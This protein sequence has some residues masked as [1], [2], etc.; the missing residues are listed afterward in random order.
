LFAFRVAWFPELQPESKI[1]ESKDKEIIVLIGLMA[2]IE[3]PPNF[4]FKVKD[5]LLSGH[6]TPPPG[7]TCNKKTARKRFF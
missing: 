7:K 3:I 4:K 6:R 1:E 5:N 2:F